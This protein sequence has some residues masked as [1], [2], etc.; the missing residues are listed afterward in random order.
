MDLRVF[1]KNCA[2]DS[3]RATPRPSKYPPRDI[4]G[5][6]N[7]SQ[8]HPVDPEK[9]QLEPKNPMENGA[10]ARWVASA[11]EP[12]LGFQNI[13]KNTTLHRKGTKHLDNQSKSSQKRSS[14]S[15]NVLRN[16]AQHSVVRSGKRISA[17]KNQPFRLQNPSQINLETLSVP[18]QPSY[19]KSGGGF[20]ASLRLG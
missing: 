4:P 7:S 16:I 15:R 19:N 6:Q 17:N 8:C 18:Y 5:S 10:F 13:K 1:G 3:P 2:L 9:H 14:R 20:A 11:L 12:G